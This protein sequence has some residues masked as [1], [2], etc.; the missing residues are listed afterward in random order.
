VAKK[1]EELLWKDTESGYAE[2]PDYENPFS[3]GKAK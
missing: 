2:M 1:A 3:K